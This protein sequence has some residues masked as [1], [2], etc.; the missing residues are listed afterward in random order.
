MLGFFYEG[1]QNAG[2]VD[3]GGVVNH[4]NLGTQ[5]LLGNHF[6][7]HSALHGVGEANLEHVV[8]GVG[9]VN[10]R[11]GGGDHEDAVFI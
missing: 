4:A 6:S 10:G 11:C 2:G 5:T 9:N 1:L 3:I 7:G 8:A